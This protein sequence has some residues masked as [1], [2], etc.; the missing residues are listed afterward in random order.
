MSGI[1]SARFRILTGRNPELIPARLDL[2]RGALAMLDGYLDA[3]AFLVDET[4]SIADIANYAYSHVAEE[5][6]IDLA[7]YPAVGAWLDRIAA[8]PDFMDDL[9]PYPDN[10]RPGASRSIYDA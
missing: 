4:C 2:G 5:A 10:A 7:E 9:A 6:G 8:L 1:G 3:R